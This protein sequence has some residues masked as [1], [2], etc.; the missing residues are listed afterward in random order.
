[1]KSILFL[2]EAGSGKTHA[3]NQLV[4]ILPPLL[5]PGTQLEIINDRHLFEDEV[6]Q[7]TAHLQGNKRVGEHSTG[8][9]DDHENLTGFFVHDNEF[10]RRTMRRLLRTMSDVLMDPQRL[11]I[12]EVGLGINNN[13]QGSDPFRW[14]LVDRL[15]AAHDVDRA[16]SA[17][18]DLIIL[19]TPYQLRLERQLARPDK[20]PEEAFRTYSG[21]GGLPSNYKDILTEL[22]FTFIGVPNITMEPD[23]FNRQLLEAIS[24]IRPELVNSGD[25]PRRQE[26]QPYGYLKRKEG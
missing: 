2:G 10:N 8:Y 7:E 20:T 6:R 25:I 18:T 17:V 26:G 12:A 1:M 4:G 15:K 3:L 11:I 23:I 5:P 24:A 16:F 21:E 9:Y 22:E 14:G 19:E 13:S